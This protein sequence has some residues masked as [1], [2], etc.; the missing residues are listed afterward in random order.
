MK[1]SH[2]TIRYAHI[3]NEFDLAQSNLSFD[4]LVKSYTQIQLVY[5]C[6]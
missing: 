6:V 1:N 3:A 2:Y 4:S 5:S